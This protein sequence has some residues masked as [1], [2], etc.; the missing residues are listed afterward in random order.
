MLDIQG[1]L[2]DIGV[3]YWTSGKNVSDGWTSISCPLCGDRSNHGAFSPDGW[4]Y[5]CFRCGGHKVP[6]VISTLTSW[7]ETKTLL[8]TYSNVLYIKEEKEYIGVSSVEWPP[9][10]VIKMPSLHAEYLHE[11]GYDPK[12][13]RELY[14]IQ[15]CY[16]TGE[17]KYRIIIP[18]YLNGRIMTYVGRDITDKAALKYK[19]LA[20]S[21]SVIPA[22][23]IVY[24]IDNIHDTAIICEGIFDAW[25]FGTHG[26]AMFG[27]QYTAQ[28][29]RALASRLRRAFIVFDTEAQAIEKANELGAD[30]ALQGVEVEIIGIE[31]KDPGEMSQE[32][33]DEVKNELLHEL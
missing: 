18:V 9:K 17:F 29:T 21:K 22:K 31:Q 23:Q 20:E 26:V 30:L 8:K 27:L 6:K 5:S 11:R 33:A 25:R 32:E 4:G 7:K 1:L 10:N 15:C 12:Q 2:G 14:D 3:P 13:L 28:Q 19:N 16:Q 24:N